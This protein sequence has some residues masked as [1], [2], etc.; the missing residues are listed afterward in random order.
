MA[1]PSVAEIAPRGDVVLVCGSGGSTKLR[2][3]SRIL[4]LASPV[5]QAMFEQQNF[6]EGR[7]LAANGL[8]EVPL[9]DDD[10]VP[11]T[12]VCQVLHMRLNVMD[13]H[14]DAREMVEIGVVAD[15]YDFCAALST[16][17]YYWC[18]QLIDGV[19][20]IERARLFVA[21]YLLK[22]EG[23]FRQLSNDMVMKT[24]SD[25]SSVFES[26]ECP[27]PL[28]EAFPRRPHAYRV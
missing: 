26:A 1:S 10:P 4:A 19:D 11:L 21:V 15:K 25:V 23:Y 8:I 27:E 28:G 12:T 3:E 13:K 9:P 18:N 6:R 7:E 17:T 16:A 22:Q 14:L 24:S 5:F 20:D 2:V